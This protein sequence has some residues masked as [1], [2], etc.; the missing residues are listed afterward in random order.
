MRNRKNAKLLFEKKGDE[1]TLEL[2]GC[3]DVLVKLVKN[4]IDDNDTRSVLKE[5]MLEYQTKVED[6]S[7]SEV[8]GELRSMEKRQRELF[9]SLSESERMDMIK[10]KMENILK[11]KK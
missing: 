2:E 7:K 9:G 3:R 10:E 8:L 4:A 6:M 11:N 5:A 1:F